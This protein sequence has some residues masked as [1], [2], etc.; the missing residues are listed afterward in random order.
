MLRR[1]CSVWV[2]AAASL[3]SLDDMWPSAFQRFRSCAA[4]TAD[5]SVLTSPVSLTCRRK[6]HSNDRPD[7]YVVYTSLSPSLPLS[8]FV[9]IIDI[10]RQASV[11]TSPVS[12]ICGQKQRSVQDLSLSHSLYI[13]IYMHICIYIHTYI[14]IYLSIYLSMYIYTIYIY[15]YICI[16]IYIYI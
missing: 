10:D 7:T 8:R 9:Y 13:S 6:Q 3:Y 12:L 1:T 2:A 5:A 15:S 14:S 16:C 11:L 4:A